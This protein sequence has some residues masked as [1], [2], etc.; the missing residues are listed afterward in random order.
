MARLSR[1]R[2][3]QNER[4]EALPVA[5]LF[6][7][8]LFVVLLGIHILIITMARTAVQAAADSAV[9]A[10]QAAGPG[11]RD[12]YGDPLILEPNRECEAVL[13]ARMSMDA[14]STS[15]TET[16]RA[17]VTIEGDRGQVTVLVFG[18]TRSPI[19]G[20]INLNAQA[21]GPLDDVPASEL[22]GTGIWQ[23]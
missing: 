14:A 2:R 15:V 1:C 21:C 9:S 16:R 6:I 3:H 5:I 20:Q 11:E 18:S 10:A 17:W 19:F 23:C 8:V 4:G 12:C 22:T 7:G 13:A